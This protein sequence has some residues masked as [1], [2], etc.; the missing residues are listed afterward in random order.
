[1]WLVCFGVGLDGGF[2]D[3]MFIVVVVVIWILFGDEWFG[4]W[5]RDLEW[6]GLLGFCVW[7]LVGWDCGGLL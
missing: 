3:R 1:M 4:G 6:F 2:V 5:V 7:L